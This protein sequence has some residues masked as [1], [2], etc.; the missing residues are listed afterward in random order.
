MVVSLEIPRGKCWIILVKTKLDL[1]NS[2]FNIFTDIGNVK[3]QSNAATL[4][5][6]LISF[7]WQFF[8]KYIH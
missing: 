1:L 6:T 7:I 5:A 8:V 3:Y 2:Y 4:H